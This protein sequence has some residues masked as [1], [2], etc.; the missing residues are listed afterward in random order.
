MYILYLGDRVVRIPVNNPVTQAAEIIKQTI[1]IEQNNA[2]FTN[3]QNYLEHV[4]K[5]YRV[6]RHT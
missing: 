4:T 5:E 6:C 2:L 3:I 1:I